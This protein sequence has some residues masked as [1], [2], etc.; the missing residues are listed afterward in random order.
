VRVRTTA[1]SDEYE[2][3][4]APNALREIGTDARR[5]T[6]DE[7]RRIAVV[8]NDKVFGYY[9]ARVLRSL[10][11]SKFDVLV[12]LVPDGERHKTLTTVERI[13]KFLN[14]HKFG[15]TDAVVALGGGVAGDIAGFSASV[16]MR[17]I[18]FINAPTTL[19]SQ[20]DASVGGKTGVN[21]ETGKNLVGAFHQPR[22]VVADLTTLKT[23]PRRE[24]IAGCC[25]M[26]K[27][28]AV[29]GKQLFKQ[30]IDFLKDLNS[31]PRALE[32]TA[33]EKLVAAQCTFKRSIVVQDERESTRRNDRRSRKILNFG[34]TVGHALEAVT[35]YRRYR[36]GEAVGVGM[37][38]AGEISKNL[39]MLPDS[40][41]KLLIDG[42][43]MCGPLPRSNDIPVDAILNSIR[44]DKKNVA[45]D[46]QWVLLERIGKPRIVSGKEISSQ[47]LKR[48]VRDALLLAST[49]R[50]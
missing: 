38:A 9:G 14:D 27:Q 3:K 45:G 32:S 34:H 4:I 10:K 41:L 8:S 47:L 39:G 25:E 7:S 15:R 36:H 44:N 6:G 50:N 11:A 28:G 30:T 29:S 23:L 40:E 46:M 12:F 37:I 42:I 22:G 35:E 16:F 43:R 13:L 24:L 48:S 31:H 26:V 1:Q 33:L 2:I 21:L 19:L 17:G 20:I 5:W 49:L 18:P